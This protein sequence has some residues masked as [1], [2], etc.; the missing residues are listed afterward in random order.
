MIAISM[1]NYCGRLV[2][3]TVDTELGRVIVGPPYGAREI[4]GNV[5]LLLSSGFLIL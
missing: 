3:S 5:S 4:E 1:G 2:V